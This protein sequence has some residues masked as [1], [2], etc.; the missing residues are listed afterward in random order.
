MMVD[1]VVIGS[2][3]KLEQDPLG[4]YKWVA[5][6]YTQCVSI[7]EASVDVLK[8]VRCDSIF[9]FLLLLS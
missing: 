7:L 2:E 1:K 8:L 5:P 9:K 4:T 3:D 6:I